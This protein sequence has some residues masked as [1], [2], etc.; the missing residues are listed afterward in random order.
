MKR[1]TCVVAGWSL[2]AC[3]PSPAWAEPVV[4]ACIEEPSRSQE[5]EDPTFF[6]LIDFDE[7][8]VRVHGRDYPPLS[9]LLVQPWRVEFADSK[10]S[11]AYLGSIDRI[12][13]EMTIETTGS[14]VKGTAGGVLKAQCELTTR[15]F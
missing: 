7:D 11:P 8:S 9:V 4:L 1:L 14:A 6:V 15:L 2:W 13:G 3:A 12:T 5:A 10:T